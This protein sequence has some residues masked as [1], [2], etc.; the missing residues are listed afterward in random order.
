MNDYRVYYTIKCKGDYEYG[1]YETLEEALVFFNLDQ[2]ALKIIKMEEYMTV[3][4]ERD[5]K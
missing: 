1:G 3:V 4:Y 2:N 5:S